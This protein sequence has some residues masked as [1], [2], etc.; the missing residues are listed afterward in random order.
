MS[1]RL[2]PI[3]TQVI[4]ITGPT[5]GIGLCT[6]RMAARR[7]AR[8]VLASRNPEALA[9]LEREIF[10]QGGEALA[11]T[12]DVGNE[13]DV[14]N[15]ATQAL[16]RFGR[17]DTWI[18]NAGVTVYGELLDVPVDDFRQIFETNFWGVVHGSLAAA[19]IL[20]SS[21]GAIINVGSTLS[22]RAIPIQGMYSAS[23]HAVK[24]FTD[25][26]RMELEAR[27]YPISVSLIKPS[28]IDTPYK[29][30]G[31]NYL[32]S[33]PEN[34]PPVYAPQIVA[35]AIL[36]CAENPVRDVFVG[37]GGKALAAME[38]VAPRLT[39]LYMEKAMF[40]QQQS[41][42]PRG[43]APYE[44]LYESRDSRLR[45]SG[46]YEGHVAQSSIY[47]TASLHPVIAGAVTAGVFAI[48]AGLAYSLLSRDPVQE[49]S[50]QEN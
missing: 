37:G 6:A 27:D 21:G 42:E 18:N 7:G 32:D 12:A 8:L 43:A 1:L 24:G 49:V 41:D 35:E 4:V 14:E 38:K 39:D 50:H 9:Q 29:E 5:S 11:V 31:R 34:P 17:I 25:A 26:L 46:G 10:S 48:G 33:S 20:R 30:H 47:T 44:S 36:H 16:S 45:E 3:Q 28:S 22:D 13:Q 23:K 40:S 15:V 2:K 19:R